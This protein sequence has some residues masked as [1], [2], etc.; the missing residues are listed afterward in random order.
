MNRTIP[1]G[2]TVNREQAKE[3]VRAAAMSA[4]SDQVDWGWFKRIEKLS[5]LCAVGGSK[6]HI[7]FLGTAFIAKAVRIDVDLFAIKPRHDPNNPRA[8]SARTLC[9][10]VLVPLSADLAID[11]GVTGR[12]PLNNQ[13][14]F[15]MTRLNDGT[16]VHQRARAAFDYMVELVTQLDKVSDMDE[17]RG[18]LAAFIAER[19]RHQIT[20]GVGVDAPSVTVNG[21]KEA[22]VT[23]VRE[24]SEGGRRAQAVVAGLLD[25]F[26]GPERVVS[27]RIND[28]SRKY[29]GD[30]CVKSSENLNAWDKAFEVKDKPVHLSDVQIFGKKCLALGVR[31]AAVVAVAA[32][33]MPLDNRRIAEWSRRLGLGVMLI[34][35][36]QTMVDQVLFWADDASPD[37]ASRAAVFIR[38][39]LIAVEVRMG[40]IRLWDELIEE[41]RSTGDD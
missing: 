39:R 18:A 6:T 15:R 40:T 3:I 38:E 9:H 19:R 22:I 37:G 32:T 17:A 30:V 36:W 31:E 20:Y 14:Y 25:V 41:V 2:I 23:F 13:P 1:M 21:L 10:S 28:P 33:Q 8:F 34:M 24:D 7:A 11:I 26:A 35:D 29:P 12:E 27:G 16:P 4:E 5:E